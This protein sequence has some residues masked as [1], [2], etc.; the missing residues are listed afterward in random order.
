LKQ[1]V[2]LGTFNK[3]YH[4]CLA[5][6]GGLIEALKMWRL[7]NVLETEWLSIRPYRT[8]D[9]LFERFYLL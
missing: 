3:P 9:T 8:D 1:R 5:L 6:T 2:P 4:P 7:D